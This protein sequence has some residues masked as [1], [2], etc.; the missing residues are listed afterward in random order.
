MAQESKLELAVRRRQIR[1]RHRRVTLCTHVQ[2][3]ARSRVYNDAAAQHVHYTQCLRPRTVIRETTTTATLK[4]RFRLSK[5]VA[6]VR[7]WRRSSS[8]RSL[9]TS[10][11]THG[12]QGSC[13][14]GLLGLPTACCVAY[15]ATF[16]HSIA[17]LASAALPCRAVASERFV[18]PC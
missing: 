14:D 1:S 4:R 7:K 16:A 11:E 10:C 17:N 15:L 18:W 13:F 8:H 3:A 6:K 12:E 2:C 9:A 5:Q